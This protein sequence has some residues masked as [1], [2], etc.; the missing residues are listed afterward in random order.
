ML[1]TPELESQS[2]GEACRWLALGDDE[3]DEHC[4][5]TGRGLCCDGEAHAF[6]LFW[7]CRE[8]GNVSV[9]HVTDA[10]F[11]LT[12]P[13]AALCADLTIASCSGVGVEPALA[14]RSSPEASE[15]KRFEMRECELVRR[16][17]LRNLRAGRGGEAL[18]N[19]NETR[20]CLFGSIAPERPIVSDE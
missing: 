19:S 7:F 11:R 4:L 2:D 15:W 17:C 12:F 20:N 16:D 3:F 18:R 9:A 1:L 10:G 5:M 14:S 13:A 8:R 6:R